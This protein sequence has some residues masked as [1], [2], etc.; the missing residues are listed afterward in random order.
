MSVLNRGITPEEKEAFD[1]DGVVC[2]RNALSDEWLDTLRG[3][4]DQVLSTPGPSGK[5][6]GEGGG[7]K[8]GYDIFMWTFNEAFRRF[9]AESPVPQW[10]AAVMGSE[11][12]YLAVD[13]L[14]VKEP[15]TPNHTPWHHDQ[16]YLWL[17]GTQ[18]CSF[19]IP[20]DRVTIDSGAVEWIPGSHRWG[21]WF[22][23]KGFEPGKYDD[24]PDIFEEIPDFEAE[25]DKHR[26]VH[27]DTEP[28]DVIAHHLLTLHHSPGNR[29]SDRRRRAVAVRYAGDDVTY[30]KRVMG[31]Q[32]LTDPGLKSGDKIACDT[33]PQVWPRIG[34]PAATLRGAAD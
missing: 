21:K 30:A 1:R 32:P 34:L 14:F 17:D 23:P 29:T 18:V 19:W 7:G 12:A 8:F 16:P 9:Q 13:A 3:A 6:L 15:N 4:I 31:P 28:G 2:L 24:Y 26:I 11:K 5:T 10:A 25:R 20:L 22:K 27:F 33:F